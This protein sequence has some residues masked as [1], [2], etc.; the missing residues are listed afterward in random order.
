MTTFSLMV[1]PKQ[2]TG[3]HRRDEDVVG[4]RGALVPWSGGTPAKVET[5]ICY[6]PGAVHF[7][8][9]TAFALLAF[10]GFFFFFFFGRFFSNSLKF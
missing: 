3:N 1:K 5:H 7:F 9:R 6:H 8:P 2:P 10:A 4:I